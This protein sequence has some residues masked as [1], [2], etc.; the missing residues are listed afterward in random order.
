MDAVHRR[1][2]DSATDVPTPDAMEAGTSKEIPPGDEEVILCKDVYATAF[3]L[4]NNATPGLYSFNP[5]INRDMLLVWFYLGFITFSQVFVLLTL[6][7]INPPTSTPSR[8]SLIV[9]ILETSLSRLSGKRT[10]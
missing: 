10:V 8:V 1:A 7:V 5:F 3:T 6:L 9:P 4:A 2:M